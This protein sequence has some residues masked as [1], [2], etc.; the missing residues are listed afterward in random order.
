[1]KIN[2]WLQACLHHNAGCQYLKSWGSPRDLA[3]FRESVP[4]CH[5]E[6]LKGHIHKVI[7]GTP[8]VLFSGV[9]AGFECTSGS[10]GHTKIIAYSQQGLED[11]QRSLAP[12]LL[13]QRQ[14]L[15]AEAQV[16]FV[17]SPA[18]KRP[19]LPNGITPGLPDTAFL[20]H[21]SA[22]WLATQSAVPMEFGQIDSVDVWRTRTQQA[23]YAAKHL[24][25]ISVWSP[26]FLLRLTDHLPASV[27]TLW[28]HLRRISC[29]T[30]GTA[31]QYLPELAAR[32]P[33]V[34]IAPKGLMATEGITTVP[35][36]SGQLELTPFGFFEFL[37]TESP[38]SPLLAHEIEVHRTYT[39]VMTTNSGLYRYNTGDQVRV[40]GFSSAQRPYLRFVGR[41]GFI[42]DLA[43]EKLSEPFVAQCLAQVFQMPV[44][45][46]ALLVPDHTHL[47]Y[48]LI[49]IAPLSADQLSA[50]EAQ[51]EQNPQY[52]Y[53][54]ALKQLAPLRHC[55]VPDMVQR[56]ENRLLS[57]GSRL[58]DIKPLTL[59]RESFW[60]PL[61]TQENVCALP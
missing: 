50:V 10:S 48:V 52:A 18:T 36:E 43:G 56:V 11:I 61:L 26:T 3:A 54:R 47:G 35:N 20:D 51:L 39:V 27:H 29:W 21:E 17:V 1:M 19:P 9:P 32:F 28:P 37:P 22:R 33:G 46:K 53:A 8:N 30:H 55:H 16:Y 14:T 57:Q 25:L 15:G 44:A 59:R 2:A 4:V 13:H 6:S 38:H 49:S 42:S 23:L 40:E 12:W 24:A 45:E 31:A 34:E 7:Q 58:G 5:Y 41:E 60:L